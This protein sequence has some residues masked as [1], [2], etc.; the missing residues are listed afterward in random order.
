VTTLAENVHIVWAFIPQVSVISVMN[1]K[2]GVGVA[3]FALRMDAEN[4]GSKGSPVVGG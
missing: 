3:D 1:L 2:T 4:V